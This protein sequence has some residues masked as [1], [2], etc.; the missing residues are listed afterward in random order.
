LFFGEL[1]VVCSVYSDIKLRK[2]PGNIQVKS[3]QI[4]NRFFRAVE[5]TLMSGAATSDI[6]AQPGDRVSPELANQPGMLGQS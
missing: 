5:R 6:R 3:N 1:V 4:E 2:K